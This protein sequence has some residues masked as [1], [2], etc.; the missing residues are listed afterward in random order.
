[1]SP[2]LRVLYL[3]DEAADAELVQDTLAMEG[4][5]CDVSRV[6]TESGFLTAL[7]QGA[8][9][10]ILAD[11]ALPS[12]DGVSA[13]KIVRQQESDLPFIF[14][15]GTMGEEIAI[16]ALKIGA[17]DYVL[18]TR[19]SRLVPAVHRALREAGE[20]TERKKAQE[21]LRRSERELRQVVE[22]IPAMVWCALPD[23]SNLLMN[24]R[25]TEYT[26]SSGAGLGWQ[27]ALHPD[28]LQRH[29]DAFR[30][31][32]AKGLPFEDEV[33]FRRA[34]GEYRWFLVQGM[35]LRD[36]QGKILN[37]YGIVTDIEDRKRAEETLREQANLLS[38]THDAIFVH[39][40][41]L[42]IRYW[43]RG[44]EELY[45]WTARE[46]EG[47]IS[48]E[49]LQTVFPVPLEQLIA[50]LLSNGRWEGEFVRTTKDGTK[51]VVA[52][53]WS[54][55]RDDKGTPLAILETNNDITERNRA[56]EERER[57]HQLEAD[58]AH[59]NRVTTM[60]ELTAGLAHEIRQPISATVTNANACMLWLKR[61][62]PD[63]EEACE[64]ARRIMEDG[65]RA[66][67]IIEHL[68]SLY[69][70]SPPKRELIEI[71]DI[72]HEIVVLLQSEA[73]KHSIVMRTEVP[74]D[75]PKI[76]ADRVQLQQV[77]MNLMLNG[78]EA[79]NETGG[80]LTIKS[81]FGQDGLLL[82]SVS[83][84]GMGLPAEYSDQI[85]NA[86]FTTKPQGS[87]MGLAISRSIVESH[88]GRLWATA[89]SERGATFHFT[90]PATV[91]A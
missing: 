46:A 79:M 65:K 2:S 26:G 3:E 11:Y 88:G 72:V 45:G 62:H 86:F 43:N 53:R 32:S 55:Q 56:E 57:L 23:G 19:L 18:K 48:H 50:E 39:D 51:V 5:A 60:G 35:P 6:E 36:E 24:N 20:R 78:I 87:G 63:L 38:L 27:A 73:N 68:R 9:D 89:N 33:R 25:W 85:F 64:A 66:T 49:L 74:S 12:F 54:L 10:L 80:I 76:T 16:E 7:Q 28:D 21:A 40:M 75:L 82:I 13:L 91:A 81:Q 29:M 1:M 83:D 34:D 67:D 22:T 30:A 44:A 17:T 61:D 77:L 37:W 41:N 84:T 58:L 4:I 31:C 71:S 8:F 59:I 15:S 69:K 70:K 14:V 42:R 90:L 52:S 47:K